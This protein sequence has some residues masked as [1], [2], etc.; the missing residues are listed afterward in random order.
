M[1]IGYFSCCDQKSWAA[2]AQSFAPWQQATIEITRRDHSIIAC[3]RHLYMLYCC[4]LRTS[5]PWW[6]TRSTQHHLRGCNNI[7][8]FLQRTTPI[9]RSLCE[10]WTPH[11]LHILVTAPFRCDRKSWAACAQS[12]APWQ[13]ATIEITWRDHSI[14]ACSRHIHLFLF[15]AHI[16]FAVNHTI[17]ATPTERLQHSP[18][19]ERVFLL[20]WQWSWNWSCQINFCGLILILKEESKLLVPAFFCFCKSQAAFFERFFV[21]M[22]WSRKEFKKCKMLRTDT[23]RFFCYDT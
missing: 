19:S 11:D 9:A 22:I 15:F 12:F 16:P 5:R 13:Q 18:P 23:L 10:G 7:P 14:I 20:F 8:S 21:N 2:C 17:N 4:S 6:I 1:T 3:S